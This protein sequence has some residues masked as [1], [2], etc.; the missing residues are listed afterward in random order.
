MTT[1]VLPTV[2]LGVSLDKD[3][4]CTAR[5][6][7]APATWALTVI[8][9]TGVVCTTAPYCTRHKDYAERRTTQ[10]GTVATCAAHRIAPCTLTWRPL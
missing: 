4:P 6:C 7:E 3:V 1:D 5:K 9:P 8:H 2:D 10:A